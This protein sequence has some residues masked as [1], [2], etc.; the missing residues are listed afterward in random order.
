MT[1]IDYLAQKKLNL[2][3]KL[4]SKIRFKEPSKTR[5]SGNYSSK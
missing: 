3:F 5:F 2:D 1:Q 4:Y